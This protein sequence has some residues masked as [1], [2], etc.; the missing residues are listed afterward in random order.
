MT[1]KLTR[2][3]LNTPNH[4]EC[5]SCLPPP[6]LCL[7]SQPSFMVLLLYLH[8][9]ASSAW[10]RWLLSWQ[11]G[12]VAGIFCDVTVSR[13]LVRQLRNI[14]KQFSAQSNS[15]CPE[16]PAEPMRPA[17]QWVGIRSQGH[18]VFHEPLVWHLVQATPL[19]MVFVVLNYPE[20]KSP[21]GALWEGW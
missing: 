18:R 19:T 20:R 14:L 16:K 15:S 11:D 10:R 12:S 7:F 9:H 6:P 3:W 5:G 4:P 21:H 17:H 8:L 13:W 2:F 1:H